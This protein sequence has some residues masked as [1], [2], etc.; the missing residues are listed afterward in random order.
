MNPGAVLEVQLGEQWRRGGEVVD[1]WQHQGQLL[2]SAVLPL[3]T[4][5]Q[6]RFRLKADPE[7]R[8]QL[9]PLP[10]ALD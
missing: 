2:V 6:A 1:V 9:R 7:A 8:L 5:A 4:E 3:D 10:Y